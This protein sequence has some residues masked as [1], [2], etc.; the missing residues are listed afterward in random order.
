MKRF[1]EGKD[2]TQMT[3]LPECL[4]DYIT[5]DNPVRAI[6]AFVDALDVTELGFDGAQPAAT[7]RPTIRRRC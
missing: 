1:M 7:G 3:L 6:D 2:R 4:E 5:E